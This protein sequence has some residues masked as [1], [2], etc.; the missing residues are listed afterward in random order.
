MFSKLD[1]GIARDHKE[2]LNDNFK[3][4]FKCGHF[5]IKIL[6]DGTWLYQGTPINRIEMVKLF[7][8]VL[9]V[10]NDGVYYLETPVEKGIIDVEDAPFIA[11]S[12]ISEIIDEDQ[13]ITFSTNL[14]DQVTVCEKNPVFV[15]LNKERNEL[16]PYVI[17]RG[18]LKALIARPVYYQLADIAVSDKNE[19]DYLGVWS[20]GNFFKL[21]RVD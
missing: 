14:G 2:L 6:R 9:K 15:E 10:D 20:R 18:N 13:H 1:A 3:K 4:R 8:T 21:G 19:P 11:V 17:V 12:M 16:L 7:S 5:G